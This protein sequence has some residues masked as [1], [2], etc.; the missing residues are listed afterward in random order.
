MYVGRYRVRDPESL[1]R[2]RKSLVIGPRKEMTKP[3]AKRKLREMLEQMGVNKTSTLLRSLGGPGETV[4]TEGYTMGE[5]RSHHV[6]TVICEYP[7]RSEEAPDSFIRR[8][9]SGFSYRGSGQGMDCGS[10]ETGK[11]GTED[12]QTCGKS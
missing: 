2:I 9:A 6:Q 10:G 1:K 3:E 11:V 4:Q 12:S 5:Y 7:L 8:P